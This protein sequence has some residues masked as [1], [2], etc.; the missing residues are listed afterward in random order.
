[1][2]L[3]N[4][5]AFFDA[6]RQELFSGNLT[7]GQVAGMNAILVAWDHQKVD[8][9]FVAYALATAYWETGQKMLPIRE[10]GLGRG[11]PYGKPAGPWKQIYYGR[12]LVQLTWYANYDKAD[13]RLRALGGLEASEDLTKTP[14]L[15]LRP[16][17]AAAI[18]TAGMV[19]GW[20]TGAKLA[21]FFNDKKDDAVDARKIINGLDRAADISKFHAH[22]CAA[23]KAGGY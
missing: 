8:L 19:E 22:F 9:R 7:Q 16:D 10:Y 1:M 14:D 2:A 12:G 18:M 4:S 21:D 17:I 3:S 23:L 20:F 11:R 6:V 5:Q 15:A 13:V